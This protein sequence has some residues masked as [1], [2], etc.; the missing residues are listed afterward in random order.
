MTVIGID[1][2]IKNTDDGNLSVCDDRSSLDFKYDDD[3]NVNRQE[4][5]NDGIVTI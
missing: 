5:K 3:D 4:K 1:R 2:H